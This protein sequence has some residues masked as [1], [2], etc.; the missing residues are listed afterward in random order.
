MSLRFLCLSLCLFLATA[1]SAHAQNTPPT[2]TPA[3]APAPT[4]SA[5]TSNLAN[6]GDNEIV[7]PIKMPDADLDTVLGAL[8]LYTG[9]SIL[10]PSA[11]AVS[12]NGYNIVLPPMPKSDVIIAIETVLELNN[13]AVLPRGDKYL[14]VVPLSNARTETPLMITGSTLDLAPSGKIASKLFMLDFLRVNEF[15]AQIQSSLLSPNIGVGFVL[16]QNSN[17]ALITDT[18]SNLQ[19]IELLLKEIDRRG[20]EKREAEILL[21]PARQGQRA[22]EQDPQLHQPLAPDSAGGYNV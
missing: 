22:R 9:R 20:F 16:L 17:A 14:V 21:A 19:R 6:L 2:P 7:G 12:P 18:I 5:A 3:A 8:V 10:R 1:F 15:V 13:I 11:L 4:D